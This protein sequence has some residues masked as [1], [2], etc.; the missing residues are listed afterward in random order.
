MR[1]K[2]F[3]IL[4]LGLLLMVFLAPGLRVSASSGYYEITDFNLTVDLQGNG[5]AQVV[6]RITAVCQGRE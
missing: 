5:D 3:G 6:E 1:R 2:G 4:L